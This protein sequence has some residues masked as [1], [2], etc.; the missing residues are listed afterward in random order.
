MEV[1]MR[2]GQ[3]LEPVMEEYPRIFDAW[4]A[5]GVRGLVF[6]RLLFT[7]PQGGFTVPA[8][9]SRP[10]AYRDRGIEPGPAPAGPPA[11]QERLLHRMLDDAKARGWTV[12]VFCPGQGTPVGQPLPLEQDPY[13]AILT[14]A[15]W[16]EVFSALPQAD[17]GIMDGW[18]ESAYE[19]GYWPP[20]TSKPESY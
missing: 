7:D 5:G 3:P 8:I 13:G 10:G 11:D 20:A 12:L 15:V 14:A 17:G 19:L 16:D 4:E 2:I 9:P 18:T 6:G 1:W